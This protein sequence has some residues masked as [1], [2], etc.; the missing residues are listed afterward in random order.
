[1][2]NGADDPV[3]LYDGAS[4]H[5]LDYSSAFLQKLLISYLYD[6]TLISRRILILYFL[7]LYF[8]TLYFIIGKR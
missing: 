3:V 2:G 4:A 6:H 8:K 7:N 5:S 1:M